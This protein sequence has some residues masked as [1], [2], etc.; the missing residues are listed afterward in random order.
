MIGLQGATLHIHARCLFRDLSFTVPAGRTL[1][2]L[3]P[4]GRGKTTAMRAVL[5][6]AALTRGRR[7][8]PSVVGYVPQTVGLL[9]GYRVIDVVTMGRAGRLGLFGQPTAADR[10]AALDALRTVGAEAFAEAQAD[11]LS[12]GERQLVLI[13]RA[14]A[15]AAPALLLDEPGSALDLQNQARLLRLLRTLGQEGRH[16]IL[17]T[18]HDP[19]HALAAADDALLLMPDGSTHFGPVDEVIEPQILHRLYGLPMRSVPTGQAAR[20]RAVVPVFG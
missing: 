19:N 17:F 2:I 6:V 3:G 9:Q 1:A 11:R 20:G 5:G 14:L 12:G 13:A 7:I 4:N 8:A 18:T 15:S 16:A 10:R